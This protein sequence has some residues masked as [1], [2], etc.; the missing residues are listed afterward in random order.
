[1]KYTPKEREASKRYSSL[2]SRSNKKR[3]KW[4]RED[5][6]SWYINKPK[7][8]YYCRCTEENIKK[9]REITESKRYVTRGKSFEIERLKDDGYSENNCVLACYWCNNA[10]SDVFTPE[11]F[12]PIGR[13]I[14][15]VIRS[16]I[17]EL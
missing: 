12:K 2:K 3:L 17:K 15:K 9:F 7:K 16:K 13:V 11:E 1:M 8:C 6:I 4:K 10:K 5:F 14:G